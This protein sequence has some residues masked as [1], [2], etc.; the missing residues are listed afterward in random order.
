MT[1]ALIVLSVALLA[2]LATSQRTFTILNAAREQERKEW[3]RERQLL[4]NRI[5]PETAQYVAPDT[6]HTP[7]AV[8]MFD[9]EDY[10]ES[11]D[12]LAERAMAEELGQ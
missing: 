6:I 5:K 9:D 3:M 10:W 7:E 12:E 1:V 2:V 8:S 4:L 11:K